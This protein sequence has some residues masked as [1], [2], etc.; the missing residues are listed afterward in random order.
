MTL[1]RPHGKYA[2][3]STPY[4]NP[5]KT[6]TTNISILGQ[7][8]STT[9]SGPQSEML[10]VPIS[11]S[12]GQPDVDSN[13][14]SITHE[15]WFSIRYR[16]G[17][18]G[19]ETITSTTLP[20]RFAMVAD[21]PQRLTR[22]PSH[23]SGVAHPRTLEKFLPLPIQDSEELFA[24]SDWQPT[25]SDEL[26]LRVGDEVAVWVEFDDGWCYGR[27]L[28]SLRVGVFPVS[29]LSP[30]VKRSDSQTSSLGSYE[31]SLFKAS[32]RK[33]SRVPAMVEEATASETGAGDGR[34]TEK[35]ANENVSLVDSGG[36]WTESV[37]AIPPPP[38]PLDVTASAMQRNKSVRTPAAELVNHSARLLHTLP[39]RQDSLEDESDAV[40]A[41]Q[42][43]VHTSWGATDDGE[44]DL[45]EGDLV[46]IMYVSLSA[47]LIQ[48]SCSILTLSRHSGD[49]GDGNAVGFNCR[50]S[51]HGV[52]PFNCIDRTPAALG[53][54]PLIASPLPITPQPHPIRNQVS[55]QRRIRVRAAQSPP[56]SPTS[57]A[58]SPPTSPPTTPLT[59]PTTHSPDDSITRPAASPTPDATAEAEDSAGPAANPITAPEAKSELI[60][61]EELDAKLKTG[62]ISGAEYVKQRQHIRISGGLVG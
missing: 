9:L 62:A 57:P 44:L 21:I 45:A 26:E 27:N 50:S 48:P 38:P 25:E 40:D 24:K 30:A 22:K 37:R 51:Q 10:R 54:N 23:R 35:S 33:S 19:T 52:F 15:V 13:D 55:I 58:T 41:L 53:S 4:R 12:L 18:A 32:E 39:P 7:P 16:L 5:D 28:T 31:R 49:A 20:I 2:K 56:T 43:R 14:I 6:K 29:V 11:K 59:T 1:H 34:S 46:V 42:Y 60:Q 47:Q 36:S 61:L 17:N 3:R 8:I